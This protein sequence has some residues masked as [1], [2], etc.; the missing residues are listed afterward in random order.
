MAFAQDACPEGW[1]VADGSSANRTTYAALFAAIGTMYGAGNGTTTFYLPDYR[2][3]FLRGW[4]HGA[5]TDPDSAIR[6]NRGD[7]TLGDAVGTRQEDAFQGHNHSASTDAKKDTA[8][9]GLSQGGA[10][11][12][13]YFGSASVSV[14]APTSDGVSGGPRLSSESRPKN[15][16]VLYCIKH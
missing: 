1:I 12:V 5:A 10:S 9:Q 6:A 14:G 4:A 7:G 11:V 2:G 13:Q 16:A 15:V 8:W 3:Q